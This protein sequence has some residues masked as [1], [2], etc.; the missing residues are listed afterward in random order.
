MK[1]NLSKGKIIKVRDLNIGDGRP[2][3]IAGPCSIESRDHIIKEAKSLKKMGVDILRGGAFKPRTSPYDFQGLGFKGVE[4]LK[5]ASE[6]TSLPIVTEVLSEDHVDMMKDYVDIFQIGSRN[7]Y[8]YSLLKKVGK[9]KKPVILKRGF[10][11]TLREWEMAAKYIELEGNENII[12]CERG[13]RTFETETRNTLDLAGAYILKEKTGYPVIVDPSHGTGKRELIEPMVKASLALD[14]DGVMIE[15]H[16]NPDD[17]KSDAAQ[18][19]D[20]ETYEKISNYVRDFYEN[21]I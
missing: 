11:A 16:P 2:L 6:K 8:N 10:S 18:T 21:R 14:F 7:M 1:N 15:V 19:I 17:S 12:F 9:T 13:I 5:E 3:L 20:Y 4:Y